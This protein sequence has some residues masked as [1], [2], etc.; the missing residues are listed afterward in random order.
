MH[1]DQDQ[2]PLNQLLLQFTHSDSDSGVLWTR[3]Q[4]DG[5][6]GVSGREW[7]IT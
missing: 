6:E 2:E 1:Q 7:M 4:T 5:K 3:R